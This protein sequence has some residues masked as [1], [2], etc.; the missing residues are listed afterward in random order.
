MSLSILTPEDRSRIWHCLV[1]GTDYLNLAGSGIHDGDLD[2]SE[3]FQKL[4]GLRYLDLTDNV[5]TRLP[6]CLSTFTELEWLG[7]NFNH[8]SSADGLEKL[9]KLKRLYLRGNSLETLPERIGDLGH[10]VEL[11]LHENRISELPSS[12]LSLLDADRDVGP[13]YF[14]LEG[15]RSALSEIVA[16]AE[17]M[18]ARRIAL[19]N[20]LRELEVKS[21]VLAQGKLLL[22]GEGGVGKTTL[23]DVLE[24]K[25]Y[26]KGNDTTHGL[27]LR[28]LE[29]KAEEGWAGTLH[30][31]DFSGQPAMRQTHQLFFTSPALYLLVWNHREAREAE[32]GAEIME[33]LTLIDQRTQGEGRVLLVAKK[34][35]DR[36]A[37]PPNFGEIMRRFGPESMDGRGGILLADPCLKLDSEGDQAAQQVETLRRR[38]AAFAAG[39]ANFNERRPVSWLN[40]QSHF[41][42]HRASVPYLPWN[43]FAKKVRGFKI[44][45]PEEYARAQHRLG[46][47]VWLDTERMRHLELADGDPSHQLVV[48]NPDWLSKAIGFVI[49]RDDKDRRAADAAV[50][51]SPAGVAAGLVSAG[52]MDAIWSAPP[53]PKSGGPLKFAKELFPFFRQLMRA[54]DIAR[55]VRQHGTL[56]GGW[57]LVPNRLPECAPA[58]WNEAWR[59]DLPQ[60]YWRV[61]LRG[62]RDESL[63]H[64]LG[65][66]IFYRLMIM[67]HGEAQGRQDFSLAAH[68]R[69][70]FILEPEGRGM[71]RIEFNGSD[72]KDA[73][74]CVGFDFQVASHQPRDLWPVFADA[75]QYLLTDLER[76]YGY[77]GIKVVRLVSCPASS[78]DR[79]QGQRCFIDEGNVSRIA[80]SGEDDWE[81]ETTFCNASGCG[82]KLRMGQLWDGRVTDDRGRYEKIEE[83]RAEILEV[84]DVGRETLRQVVLGRSDFR[85]AARSIAADL[86]D[87]Q[88]R[89]KDSA[90]ADE[91]TVR[92]ILEGQTALAKSLRTDI[93]RV[94]AE[95]MAQLRE[96]HA[97]LNDTNNDLPRFYSL[98]PVEGW[99]I[100]IFTKRKWRLW[101]HCEKTGLPPKLLRDDGQ[102]EFIIPETQDFIKKAAPYVKNISTVLAGLAPLSALLSGPTPFAAIT[103][104]IILALAQWAKDFEK[105]VGSLATMLKDESAKGE[106]SMNETT[107]RPIYAERE[108]LL[109]LHN[110]LRKDPAHR[111]KLGLVQ[112]PDG[113]GR[114]W[115]V[116]PDVE[117]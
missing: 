29:I 99:H 8:L 24:G 79:P 110:F 42:D 16:S 23:L 112:K 18:D 101:L 4:T 84:K 103:P 58:A 78:C 7:L 2:G 86:S 95:G 81:K 72:R 52:Q 53:Q 36:S 25:A 43:E 104:A 6:D 38:I 59:A 30:A 57:H 108:G 82:K 27:E 98:K 55:P 11:D 116:L 94:I 28:R 71:A 80:H 63:N 70:G 49:E 90:L 92:K 5:L 20:Y 77:A 62:E 3:D 114:R 67:L 88:V 22:V 33:W 68:W 66:A 85:L 15:N 32:T 100:P 83:L 102:G 105:P 117:V 44:T 65:L 69:N 76:H 35:K 107:D 111:A 39:M 91:R 115:W 50:P 26:I 61:E 109:W 87:V 1:H 97:A 60:V 73:A 89:L 54:F 41:Q 31:W 12:F 74:R 13:L 51:E 113:Q 96:H 40:A 19:A 9:T 75:L 21:D 93:E 64:W 37:E 56:E 46:T 45:D 48:L 10:L 106:R 47:L 17:G 14:D 34:A